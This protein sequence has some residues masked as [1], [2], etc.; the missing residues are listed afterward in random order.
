MHAIASSALPN[1]SEYGAQE[2]TIT[3]TSVATF[4]FPDVPLIDSLASQSIRTRAA[5]DLGPV[6]FASIAWAFSLLSEPHAKTLLTAISAAAIP[7]RNHG[8]GRRHRE[9]SA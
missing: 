1:I 5:G 3:A 7:P 2:L 4:K 8:S 6:E 9:F